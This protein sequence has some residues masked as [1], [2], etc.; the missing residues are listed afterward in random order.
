MENKPMEILDDMSKL[1]KHLKSYNHN[2]QMS[3]LNAQ[4]MVELGEQLTDAEEILRT[5]SSFIEQSGSN[6]T[7]LENLIEKDHNK[8]YRGRRGS[9]GTGRKYC[10]TCGSL[11]GI[12]CGEAEP[13]YDE[14]H[15]S[16][17][18]HNG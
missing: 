3:E 13:D 2:L 10:V 17:G 4:R 7:Y 14:N 16:E 9:A 1:V 5:T 6:P 11:L 8:W 18:C 15:C 12:A